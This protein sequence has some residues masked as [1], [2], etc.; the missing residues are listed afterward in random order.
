MPNDD[1]RGLGVSEADLEL[2]AAIDNLCCLPPVPVRKPA[3]PVLPPKVVLGLPFADYHGDLTSVGVGSLRDMARSPL[4]HYYAHRR[5]G[6][7][8][9]E[10]TPAQ[11]LGTAI[12][13]AVLEPDSFTHRFVT[14]PDVDRRTKEGKAT[15]SAFL[16]KAGKMTKLTVDQTEAAVQ[17]AGAVRDS[18]LARKLLKHGRVE[19]S[20]YWT[21]RAT[22]VRCRM[23]PDF[24]PDAHP[25][26]VDLKSC[27][28]ADERAFAAAA[29]RN[30]Y[31]V[32]AAWYVDGWRAV[33]NE[34]RDYIFAAWEKE[35]P[36]ASAWYY[37]TDEMLEAGRAEYR[38]LLAI[39]ADCL[40]KD[41]WPG[42]PAELQPL[43]PPAWAMDHS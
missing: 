34:K 25:V 32:T 6:R 29:W 10:P 37:A 26:I 42:Y 41:K 28:D 1:F 33:A 20:C 24:L 2:D 12:H 15:Y 17:V 4:H 43:Y 16:E 13:C 38:R 30:G 14:A 18:E 7:E 22:G 40:A 23:R 36:Y 9:E 19:L 39:Y 27:V 11:T 35:P 21:D 3:A 8:P 31:H 5:P